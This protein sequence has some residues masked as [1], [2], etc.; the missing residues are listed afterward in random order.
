MIP[1]SSTKDYSPGVIE[2]ALREQADVVILGGIWAVYAKYPEF[3]QRLRQ[4]LE[5]LAARNIQAVVALDV[6][7][8][9]IDVPRAL[10]RSRLMG[11]ATG[12]PTQSSA[13]Y[14][15]PT[16]AGR[17]DEIIRRVARE[18]GAM[19]LDPAPYLKDPQ[20]NWTVF[21]DG[22]CLYSDAH[23]LSLAGGRRLRPMFEAALEELR[24]L[25]TAPP[26]QPDDRL[27]TAPAPSR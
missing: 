26:S 20:G 22:E 17:A 27:E 25:P 15:S 18:T 9:E 5:T 21:L 24:P 11:L 1:A 8:Y 10:V 16:G 7:L 4:T 13:T 23:H 6:P 14:L 19:I 3:E 12:V 2:N